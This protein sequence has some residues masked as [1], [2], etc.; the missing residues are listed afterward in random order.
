LWTLR[1]Q[2]ASVGVD[3]GTRGNEENIY[4]HGLPLNLAEESKGI[5]NA[6]RHITGSGATVNE[7]LPQTRRRQR[8]II[9]SQEVELFVCIA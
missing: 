9:A 3:K 2:H 4:P 8:T 6:I 7:A 5:L 1:E